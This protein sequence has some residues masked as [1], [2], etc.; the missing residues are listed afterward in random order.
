MNDALR[1]EVENVETEIKYFPAN[2]TELL[3]PAGSS[4]IQKV[5]VA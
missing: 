1:S 3:Q 2:E 4:S 5:K